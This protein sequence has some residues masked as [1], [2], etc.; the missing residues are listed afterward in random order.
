MNTEN[1]N[2]M[3]NMARML[4]YRTHAENLFVPLMN[5]FAKEPDSDN[6][7]VIFIAS[8]G[9]FTEQLVS[10]G[11]MSSGETFDDRIN[12]VVNNTRDFMKNENLEDPDKNFFYYKDFK[13]DNFLFKV[14]IQ[15]MIFMFNGEKKVIRQL[16]SFF[17]E[18]HFHDFYQLSL[19]AGPFTMPTE[20]LKTGIVDL[21]NDKVTQALVNMNDTLMANIKYNS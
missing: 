15:D 13:T 16:N 8:G 6:P 3:S 11:P 10:D 18:P 19:A 4:N 5:G 9:G 2:M 20:M 17:L 1:N 21:E 7:Q 14:Y 12:L